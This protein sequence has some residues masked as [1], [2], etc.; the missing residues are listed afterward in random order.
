MGIQLDKR[1]VLRLFSRTVA[2]PGG[3]WA[4]ALAQTDPSKENLLAGLPTGPL[5]AAGSGALSAA[6][7]EAM[8]KFSVGMMKSVPVTGL[9]EEQSQKMMQYTGQMMQGVMRRVGRA[10]GGQGRRA[11]ALQRD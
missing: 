3:A 8:A 2:V 5:V 11:A 7:W 9:T 1:N 6:T 4:E 10:G